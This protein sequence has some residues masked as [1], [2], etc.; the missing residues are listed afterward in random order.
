[1]PY[2]TATD[3][4]SLHVKDMGAGKPVVL[5]HGWPLTGDMWEK[6]TL[7]L[8][9]AG[10]RVITYDRRGFGQSGHPINCYD[11]DTLA[12][13]L[14]VILEQL[15]LWDATLVGFSMGGG[16]VARYL[17]RHGRSRISKTV[18]LSSVVPF[19]LKTSDNPKGVD[20]SVFDGIKQKIRQDRFGFLKD[21]IPDFY[22]VSMIHHPV[23]Q[24]VLDWTFLLATMASPMATLDCVDAWGTTDFRPDLQAFTIPTLVIHGTA[25]SAVPAGIA[26]EKAAA[27]IPGSTWISYDGAP[28]GL[29]M[30]HA[31]RVNE[32]LLRFLAT[33]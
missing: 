22:G 20:I 27:A 23:S 28:H 33:P 31:E 15:D 1:M 3:G 16:E 26:G 30:T 6:Q 32:D 8:V 2:I 21:F 9:E 4:T 24:G 19:L 14:A 18:L 12:D 29:F 7:A 17:S 10:Y 5:I 25:D 11:Y 13:D